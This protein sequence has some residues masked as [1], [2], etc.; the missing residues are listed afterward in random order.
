VEPELTE[1]QLRHGLNLVLQ[2]NLRGFAGGFCVLLAV[3]TAA[4]FLTAT[5]ALREQTI[6]VD[7]MC[8]VALL[9]IYLLIR[10]W[11]IPAAWAHPVAAA[12]CGAI[13]FD[14]LFSQQDVFGKPLQSWDVALLIVGA[15]CAVLSYLWLSIII[16]ASLGSWAFL[17]WLWSPSFDWTTALFMHGSAVALGV[18]VLRMR[19]Q[20]FERIEQMRAREQRHAAEIEKA[21]EAVQ[22]SEQRFQAL[23]EHSN[24]AFVLLSETGVITAAGPSTERVTGYRNEDLVG[25][26]L[27]EFAHPDDRRLVLLLL[28]R[29]ARQAG[30]SIGGSF[31]IRNKNGVWMW[32]EGHLT[33]LLSDP[34]VRAVVGN[35]RDITQRHQAEV[36]LREAKEAAEAA[37]TA[38]SEFLANM[39]HEI[40]T[41][42]N[43][44]LGLTELVLESDLFDEQ[45]EQMKLVKG[46]AESLLAI[47]NEIL[48]FSKV[49]SG[50]LELDPVEFNVRECVEEA[51][52]N[53]SR[54]AARKGL[55]LIGEVSAD[56][57]EFLVGDQGRLRQVLVNLTGN[58]VKFTSRG[59]VLVQV[60]VER[61]EGGEV[62]LRFGVRDTGIGIA[63]EKKKLIFQP[64]AQADGSTTRRYGGTG[65]GLT[66]SSRLV[67]MMGGEI[68]VESEPGMGSLFHFTVK[69]GISREN[70]QIRP[71]I[72]P[73]GL[74]GARVLLISRNSSMRSMLAGELRRLGMAPVVTENVDTAVQALDGAEQSKTRPQIVVCDTG[75]P[76]GGEGALQSRIG[77]IPVVL[78]TPFGSAKQAERYLP[79][80]VVGFVSKPVR[81]VELAAALSEAIG[82]SRQPGSSPTPGERISKTQTP[83]RILLAED[84]RVNQI[85]ACRLLERRGHEVVVAPNGKEA[86]RT[87]ESGQFDVVLMDLQMPE[88]DGMETTTAIR[89]LEA[90]TGR[91]VP[92]V[93]LTAHARKEEMESCLAAGM[94]GYVTKPARPGVLIEKVESLAQKYPVG[95]HAEAS[96]PSTI[97]M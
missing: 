73:N 85:V 5:G 53:L 58:A 44:I 56:T 46:S 3:L 90:V 34:A 14:C 89:R 64:F 74:A 68:E 59:E 1:T 37:N 45:R 76:L 50:K 54:D 4:D 81:R 19:V 2:D 63:A 92:I 43:G 10:R 51:L 88:M 67:R 80:W 65:L 38:K 77:R 16:V 47:L 20:T 61:E 15:S 52:G 94:D 11:E 82:A 40:R 62:T 28:R 95:D 69:L 83:L 48:D 36:E 72:P 12:I 49:E 13:C 60:S 8:L 42:M 29:T 27:L 93:A 17:V 23:A 87:L 21:H 25:R 66:I 35:Y 31:R 86:M 70:G 39:S 75:I 33:N 96:F 6:I 84:N 9:A 71:V 55:E 57:P 24:D 18:I 91:H 26:P 79:L 32:V 30:F 41:P 22:A 78:L 97:L 7:T